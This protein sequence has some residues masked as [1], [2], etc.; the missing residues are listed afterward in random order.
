M[1]IRQKREQAADHNKWQ[2]GARVW[3]T[4]LQKA[5]LDGAEGIIQGEANG[6]V[7]VHLDH[8]KG[9]A[10]VVVTHARFSSQPPGVGS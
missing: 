10:T 7:V 3:L 6:S 5:E 9:G 4:G 2:P 8:A 1:A